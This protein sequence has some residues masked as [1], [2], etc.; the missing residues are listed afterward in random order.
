LSLV[1]DGA[2]SLDD[3]IGQRLPALPSAWHAVMQRQLLNHTSG[4]PD[5]TE[6]KAFREA[7]VRSLGVAPPPVEL[8]GFVADE[9]LNFTPG[10]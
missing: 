2:L 7:V 1:D 5:F 3:T 10:T 4:L 9:L 8:L 6:S